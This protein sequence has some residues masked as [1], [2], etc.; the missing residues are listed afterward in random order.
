MKKQ[1]LLI[2]TGLIC[3]FSSIA[4]ND[5]DAMRYSQITFGGTA[6]FAAMGGSM[7]ALGG[8][9]ST[10]AFNPAGIAVFRKNEFTFSPSIFSQSTNSTFNGTESGDRKLN[11]NFGNL[12]LVTAWDKKG[13]DNG[14]Q[15]FNFGLAYNRT[16]NFHNRT[17]VEGTNATS[18]LLDTYVANA[19]G[20]DHT[21]FDQFST[22]LAWNTWL[23]NPDTN[24]G[25]YMYNHVIPSYGQLQRKSVETRGSMG[26]TAISFG[27]NFM[28]KLLV[29]ATLGIVN[30]RY[31]EE[32]VYEEIDQA[33]SIPNFESFTFTQ[34]L[35]ARGTGA[36]FK[37]GLIYKAFD[38]MRVGASVHTP[39][40]ISFT[41]EYSSTMR[42]D[43]E[44]VSYDTISPKGAFD[45]RVTTPFRAMG[46]IGF[47]VSK[48]A[49]FNVDYEYVD[50]TYAQL[51]SRPNVFANVNRS[52]RTKYT[53][54]ANIRAGAEFRLDPFAIRLG[55]ALYGSPYA[56]GE[57]VNA[58]RTSYTFGF[59]LREKEYFLD[60][61][62]VFT[63]FTEYNY[64]YD[65][66]LVS[67]TKN[68]Y[69]NSSFMVTM[70]V[71]F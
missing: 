50:Y 16:N 7:G 26:E 19:N 69:K 30:A 34:D 70:G 55:Y 59:G 20:H 37:L 17:Y 27:G 23:V 25:A 71:K 51:N 48:Y 68:E 18:S 67:S 4:Q 6:R 29:G 56:S 22:G 24:A 53:S 11:F 60:F 21:N 63:N 33:D 13:K 45:Y 64:L 57:N 10:L 15:S 38:W 52:I 9:V 41:D 62:Y 39:T 54:T 61:A 49:L 5:I 12:G 40:S 1:A 65:P 14:W 35:T 66:T 42:S 36:N 32:S 47:I 8:D 46:S 2:S 58:A 28:D 31:V 43:L 44:S 3:A